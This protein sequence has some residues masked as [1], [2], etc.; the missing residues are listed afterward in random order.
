[1][2]ASDVGAYLVKMTLSSSDQEKVHDDIVSYG[3]IVKN[4]HWLI[5]IV[6]NKHWL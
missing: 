2:F 5:N 4:K 3:K 1:M 6:K